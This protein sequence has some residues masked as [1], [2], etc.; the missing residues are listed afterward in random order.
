MA[1]IGTRYKPNSSGEV[2]EVTTSYEGR[3]VEIRKYVEHRNVSDT[4]DYSD[5]QDVKVTDALVYYGRVVQADK[6]GVNDKVWI[7][8]R[9]VLV[10]TELPIEDR[11]RW[12]D[13]T[14]T[15][16]WR[17][18]EALAPTIDAWP[19]GAA[20]VDPN[21]L[22]DYAA[23]KAYNEE[24]ARV[25]V[26]RQQANDEAKRKALEESERQRPVKGKQMEVFK[27]RKVPIGTKG[28]VAYVHESGSVLL[29]DD[30]R[31]QDRSAPGTWVAGSNLR[32][33]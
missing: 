6:N 27:G 25:K 28:T 32:T 7:G 31:W 26:E 24:Q 33:R 30:S 8:S 22:D 1:I 4:M 20:L 10:G 9:L 2:Q 12:V 15:F 29:K 19:L 23:W 14:N 18:A 11:F 21:F 16:V 13:C 17:G 5:Y 3:V